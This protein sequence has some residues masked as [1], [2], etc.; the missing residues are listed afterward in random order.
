MK[1]YFACT[2]F[3]TKSVLTHKNIEIK[4]L[5]E[6]DDLRKQGYVV[7]RAYGIDAN[8]DVID[9]VVEQP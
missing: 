1:R 2:T 6:I 4:S 7:W 5:S 8:N 3:T 9:I